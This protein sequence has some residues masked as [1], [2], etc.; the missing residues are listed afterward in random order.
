MQAGRAHSQRLRQ[1]EDKLV[2]LG[3][4]LELRRSKL[5]A[6]T[7]RTR[8]AGSSSRRGSS[9]VSRLPRGSSQEAWQGDVTMMVKRIV[10]NIAL[11]RS[12]CGQTIII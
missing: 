12:L 3:T 2:P 11:H 5:T 1:L 4:K 7:G 10:T 8:V 6:Y 9:D